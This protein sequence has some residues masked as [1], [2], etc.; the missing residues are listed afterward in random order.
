MFILVLK[1]SVLVQKN[2]EY[3]VT[4]YPIP[5]DDLLGDSSANIRELTVRHV[6]KLEECIRKNPDQWLWLHR[7]WKYI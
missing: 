2:S 4:F 7:R 1:T 6:Q 5:F 3:N